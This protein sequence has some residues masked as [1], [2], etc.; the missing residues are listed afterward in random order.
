MLHL[1]FVGVGVFGI[2]LCF[3]WFGNVPWQSTSL[4]KVDHYNPE[5]LD[6]VFTRMF[7]ALV[8]AEREKLGCSYDTL[9]CFK[10]NMCTCF[11]AQIALGKTKIYQIDG[12]RLFTLAYDYI[13][14]LYIAMDKVL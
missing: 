13:L 1:I 8:G 2:N 9:V 7:I 6:I 5:S 11:R 4:K 14:W 10:W 12:A 3:F